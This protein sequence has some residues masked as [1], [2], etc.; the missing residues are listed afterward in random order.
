MSTIIAWALRSETSDLSQARDEPLRLMLGQVGLHNNNSGAMVKSVAKIIVTLDEPGQWEIP[1]F[2]LQNDGRLSMNHEFCDS[3]KIYYTT[4][5]SEPG[6]H[7]AVYNPSTSDKQP[8]LIQPVS[9]EGV[10]VVKAVVV[11]FGKYDSD[12]TPLIGELLPVG[13]TVGVVVLF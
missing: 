3:V 8:A 10:T 12:S 7:S 2:S 11:G 4:D 1:A 6:V 13:N 5:G 9:L